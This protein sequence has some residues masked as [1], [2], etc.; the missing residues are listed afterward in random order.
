MTQG[1]QPVQTG[2]IAVGRIMLHAA[3]LDKGCSS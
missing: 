2:V 1:S 3:K